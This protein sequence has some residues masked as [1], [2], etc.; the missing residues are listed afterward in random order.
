[1]WED[2]HVDAFGEDDRAAGPMLRTRNSIFS[3]RVTLFAG[4]TGT[5]TISGGIVFS[6]ASGDTVGT[7]TVPN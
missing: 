5:A 2:E 1:V 6:N 4:A 7:F 3:T